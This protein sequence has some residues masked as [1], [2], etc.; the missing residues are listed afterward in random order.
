MS[1][2]RRSSPRGTVV[3]SGGLLLNKMAVDLLTNGGTENVSFLAVVRLGDAGFAVRPLNL[4]AGTVSV[5]GLADGRRVSVS[6]LH[7]LAKGDR[8][9]GQ[10]NDAEEQLEFSKCSSLPSS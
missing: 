8:L 5:V 3:H 1:K 6:R 2:R 4:P 7:E 10:W 9:D